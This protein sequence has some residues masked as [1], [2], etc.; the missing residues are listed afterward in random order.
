[1]RRLFL[2]IA[3]TFAFACASPA[4]A[5][6][7]SDAASQADTN[8]CAG[9]SYHN[10]DAEPNRLYQKI[11]QRLTD[12]AATKDLTT[13]QRAWVAFRTP[14]A[15][16]QAPASPAAVFIPLSMRVASRASRVRVSTT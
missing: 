16:L 9:K 7:C 12:A 5:S 10:A 1:M 11:K 3:S 14:N 8:E 13:A 2:V 4:L 15:P 6:D